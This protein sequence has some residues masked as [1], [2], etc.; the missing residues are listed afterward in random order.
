MQTLNQQQAAERVDAHITAAVDQLRPR[1]GLEPVRRF[2]FACAD[3]T[4]HGPLGRVVVE[5]RY[6][7]PAIDAADGPSVLD[8]LAEYWTG[9]GYLILRDG[10]GG[11]LAEIAAEAPDGF[12]VVIA[13]DTQGKLAIIGSSP[14]VWPSG[15]PPADPTA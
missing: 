7:L 6:E 1:P 5:H 13:T 15:S 14:C 4:D 10:R 9:N 8:T 3:P 2:A 11:R 12:R